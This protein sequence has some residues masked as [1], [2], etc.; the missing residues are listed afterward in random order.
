MKLVYI[1]V[2]RVYDERVLDK[3]HYYEERIKLNEGEGCEGL[4]K[5]QRRNKYNEEERERE[6]VSNG[7][8]LR[9]R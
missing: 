9:G 2:R 5:S 7:V 3:A 8:K 6:G 4:R 1:K